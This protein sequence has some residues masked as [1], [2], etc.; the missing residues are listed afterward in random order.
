MTFRILKGIY[1]L[2]KHGTKTFDLFKQTQFKK[3][4]TKISKKE[5]H[6]HNILNRNKNVALN[7]R[8]IDI[9]FEII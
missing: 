4:I 9:Y 3:R 1:A 2:Y 6:I 7:Y 5:L 8:I